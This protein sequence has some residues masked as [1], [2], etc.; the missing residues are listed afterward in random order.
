MK[1]FAKIVGL[2]YLGVLAAAIAP[3]QTITGQ[4]KDTA[5][6]IWTNSIV[7]FHLVNPSG[8]KPLNNVTLAPITTD[9]SVTVNAAGTFTA[10]FPTLNNLNISPAGTYWQV[11][12]CP[13]VLGEN[14]QLVTTLVN[15]SGQDISF[16]ISAKLNPPTVTP[17]S[18]HVGGYAD[19]EIPN[20][21]YGNCYLQPTLTLRC[22]TNNV[23][24][25]VI[26]ATPVVLGNLTASPNIT[27]VVINPFSAGSLVLPDCQPGGLATGYAYFNASTFV[28]TVTAPNG[29]SVGGGAS[30]AA[31]KMGVFQPQGSGPSCSWQQF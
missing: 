14:C 8:A 19:A 26:G 22:R 20:P 6:I 3:A 17:L 13:F 10:T 1:R 18:K 31:G 16:T 24:G 25:S 7:S 4:V 11:S 15:Q 12:I 21:V 30:I 5:G 2:I 23:W 28:I 29:E 9:F 27:F